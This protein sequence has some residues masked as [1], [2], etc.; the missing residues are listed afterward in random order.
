MKTKNLIIACVWLTFSI[1]YLVLIWLGAAYS[2]NPVQWLIWMQNDLLISFVIAL[3]FSGALF[4][5]PEKKEQ[6][7]ELG[8]EL[9]NIKSRL[10]ALT[11]QLEQIKKTIRE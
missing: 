11:R 3:V 9:Q 8:S 5:L 10:D 4:L 7:T 1:I 6:E 2:D